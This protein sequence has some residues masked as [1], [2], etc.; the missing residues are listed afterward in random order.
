[1]RMGKKTENPANS[2]KRRGKTKQSILRRRQD[3]GLP[4]D[5][6]DLLMFVD[7]VKKVCD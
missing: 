3:R 2:S 7:R 4:Y 1:M 5:D 6:M